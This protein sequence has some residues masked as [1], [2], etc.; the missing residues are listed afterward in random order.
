M[1]RRPGLQPRLGRIA[2]VL[3]HDVRRRLGQA[4]GVHHRAGAEHLVDLPHHLGV[5]RG[6]AAPQVELRG[7]EL[8]VREQHLED[9]V[10]AGHERATLLFQHAERLR[11]VEGGQRHDRGARHERHEERHRRAAD[12]REGTDAEVAVVRAH[13]DA[14]GDRRR[15]LQHVAMAEHHALRERRRPRGVLDQQG[16]VGAC[17]FAVLLA[18]PGRVVPARV[19]RAF[20]ERPERRDSGGRG[21]VSEHDGSPEVGKHA[22]GKPGRN[23]GLDLLDQVEEVRFQKTPREEERLD[24]GLVQ[25][26]PQL[27]GAEAR[28]EGDR[29][30]ADRRRGVAERRP[31]DGV[32]EQEPHVM[33]AADARG[34]HPVGRAPHVRAERRVRDASGIGHERFRRAVPRDG[35]LEDPPEGHGLR[36]LDA[37]Q[38]HRV[39]PGAFGAIDDSATIAAA[40]LAACLA[41]M[42]LSGA[43]PA[44]WR[45]PLGPLPVC[46][47]SREPIKRRRLSTA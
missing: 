6:P 43:R 46:Q 10:V 33:P 42:T 11:Q 8:R 47:H 45:R 7:V 37:C 44:P 19:G 3:H 16:V 38:A 13:A 39:S 4:V 34:G 21:F 27:V 5:D 35:L 12:V 36:Q 20:H 9:G 29:D 25:A 30:R 26:E 24:P 15:H 31:L 23:G 41:R 14:R 1:R 22:P 28:V 18:V 32:A 40:K 2:R 17:R